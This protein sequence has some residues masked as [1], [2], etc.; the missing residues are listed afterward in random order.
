MVA[1]PDE[2]QVEAQCSMPIGQHADAN[3]YGRP[4]PLKWVTH[5]LRSVGTVD[6][7]MRAERRLAA[8]VRKLPK[9]PPW[10]V[11][12]F[13]LLVL[14]VLAAGESSVANVR[15]VHVALPKDAE[16]SIKR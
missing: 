12:P 8:Q 15:T 5:R 4:L 3:V 7:S 16:S 14:A 2:H 11:G 1:P 9:S 13:G 10:V 6:G